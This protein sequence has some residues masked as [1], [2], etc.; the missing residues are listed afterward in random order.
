MIKLKDIAELPVAESAESVSFVVHE[1]GVAKQVPA[2][3]VIIPQVQAD[4]DNRDSSSPGYILNRPVYTSLV[5]DFDYHLERPDLGIYKV[6]QFYNTHIP[7][8]RKPLTWET[9]FSYFNSRKYLFEY[10]VNYAGQLMT[11]RHNIKQT[12]IH[13]IGGENYYLEFNNGSYRV[14]FIIDIPNLEEE[15]AE[16]FSEPSMYVEILKVNSS[17][18]SY[19]LT[20]LEYTK[21]RLNPL[22]L[23][24]PENLYQ[25]QIESLKSVLGIAEN[26]GGGGSGGEKTY[27]IWDI[28]APKSGSRM[29][30]TDGI[31]EAI[32]KNIYDNQVGITVKIFGYEE[33]YAEVRI[34][35][36]TKFKLDGEKIQVTP[37]N[38]QV[39][40]YI[41]SENDHISCYDG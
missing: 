7:E 3:E 23:P 6:V 11:L 12:D 16:K 13:M 14:Y 25:D 8:Q 5:Q 33:D 41:I 10:T 19:D 36:A 22:H 35:N 9:H 18:V 32:K 37:D 38:G 24:N 26:A 1:D 17:V 20:T 31:Y 27:Y 21:G 15:Y 34:G 29:Y 39:A 4:W 28:Y 40:Y 2:S 30:A